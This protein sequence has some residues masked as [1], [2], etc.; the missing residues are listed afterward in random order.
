MKVCIFN[1]RF[2][3][4]KS[5]ECTENNDIDIIRQD[6]AYVNIYVKMSNMCNAKCNF[7]ELDEQSLT[8]FDYYKFYCIVNELVRKKVKIKKVSFTGGE[9]TLD[10]ELLD[11]CIDLV[12][13]VDKNI[14]VVVNTNGLNISKMKNENIDSIALSR[15]HYED[16]KNNEIFN[17]KNIPTSSELKRLPI[18]IKDKIHLSCNIIKEHI[19]SETDVISYLEWCNNIGIKDV[20]F[21]NLMPLN[22]YCKDNFVD[23][24]KFN[25]EEITNRFIK[26][27]EYKKTDVCRCANYLYFSKDFKDYIKI[28]YRYVCKKDDT[29]SSL[30]YDVNVLKDGFN[31]NIII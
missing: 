11:R 27:R 28:Y 24:N 15:H 22:K 18:N 14:F 6:D 17:N 3:E 12:K 7:C 10:M 21:V 20:G 29:N 31:G 16:I 4:T 13:D 2:I 5:F 8:G 25:I 26:V 30:V 19:G 1:N 23:F 9:P